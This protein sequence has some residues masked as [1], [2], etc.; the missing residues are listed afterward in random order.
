VDDTREG[1]LVVLM[2]AGGTGGHIF[3]ALAVMEEIAERYPDLRFTWL[4]SSHRMESKLIPS[5][6]IDFIGLRQTEFRRKPTPGNVFYNFRTLWFLLISIFQSVRIVRKLKPRLVISTGG[7]AAGAAGIAAWLTKTPL[8][9]IEPNVY[10]G[11]TN[12]QLG[13]AA[14]I[15][16]LGYPETEKFFPGD[17]TITIGVPARSEISSISRDEAR[18]YLG[19]GDDTVMILATGGSQG[20][21]SINAVLPDAIRLMKEANPDADFIVYHQCGGRKIGE[22]K[23]DRSILPESQYKIIEFID[24]MPAY[25]AAADIVISRAGAST[26][27]EIACRGVA[28][29]LIPYPLASENH[30]VRNARALESAGAAYCIEESELSAE[31]LAEIITELVNNSVKRQSMG[32]AARKFGNP[33]AASKIVEH[34]K[35]YLE[36]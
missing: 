14:S 3:P 16:F 19:I 18:R 17:N 12:R 10:P 20:A 34:L 22:V 28:S 30:Q 31:N 35:K 8:A 2:A 33:E 9:I 11:I 1:S 23:A 26:V 27:S 4:G 24:D 25:L 36:S 32:G 15:V 29:V 13:R 6:G 5:R 7:F 21:K